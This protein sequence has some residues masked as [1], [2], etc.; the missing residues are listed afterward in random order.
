[1]PGSKTKRRRIP[2][3][4]KSRRILLQ[5]SRGIDGFGTSQ[6][7]AAVATSESLSRSGAYEA[8]THPI[9]RLTAEGIDWGAWPRPGDEIGYA[10]HPYR[11]DDCFASAIATCTQVPIEQVPD[12]RLDRRF[13]SGEDLDEI[14]R[15]SWERVAN[16]ASRRGLTLR[17]SEE[18]PLQLDRWIGVV[19]REAEGWDQRYEQE[20]R[21]GDSVTLPF[22][23]HCLVMAWDRLHFDPSCGVRL[24]RGATGRWCYHPSEITYGIAF[25]EED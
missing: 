16:W 13:E 21:S 19:H 15:S 4:G 18:L 17:F 22:Q 23:D 14:A 1:M 11:G 7:N 12:L 6:P 25:I 9:V 3:T 20:M 5:P 8:N 10:M 24:P 2:G